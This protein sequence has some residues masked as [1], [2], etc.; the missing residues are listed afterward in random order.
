MGVDWLLVTKEGDGE[1]RLHPWTPGDGGHIPL[2]L[3]SYL[4]GA[5]KYIPF[6]TKGLVTN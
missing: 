6:T 4:Q 2:K 5:T 3:D 1:W